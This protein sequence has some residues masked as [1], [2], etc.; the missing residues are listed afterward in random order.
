[1]GILDSLGS[2]INEATSGE[3]DEK[4][5]KSRSEINSE[6]LKNFQDEASTAMIEDLP[7][8]SELLLNDIILP[9]EQVIYKI[10]SS[11]EAERSQLV[12]T[13]KNLIIFSKGIMGGQGSDT[14]DGVIGLVL[15]H[16]L[17]SI[18]IYPIST[19]ESFEIQPPRGLTV[20]HFQIFTRMTNEN[21]NETKFLFED[22]LGYF[23]VL[24]VYKKIKELQN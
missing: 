1:M 9:G 7:K 12:L 10:R 14:G 18:R 24:N 6:E 3:G 22:Y 16:K 13:N 19:L 21:D 15:G 11:G 4:Q 17:M 8:D 23:K 20:G 2:I 5:A